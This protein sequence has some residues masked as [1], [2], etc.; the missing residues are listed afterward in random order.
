MASTAALGSRLF[1]VVRTQKNKDDRLLSFE[2][3]LKAKL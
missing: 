3:F 1:G 2:E